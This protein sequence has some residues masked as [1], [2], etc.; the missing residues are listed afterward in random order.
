MLSFDY[1]KYHSRLVTRLFTGPYDSLR[2]LSGPF[3]HGY[4]PQQI[5][6][7]FLS[8]QDPSPGKGILPPKSTYK[9]SWRNHNADRLDG[10]V[11]T[12]TD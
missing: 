1:R 12:P 5:L 7:E 2:V 10:D 8:C 11:P 6:Y 4:T 9:R 3:Y